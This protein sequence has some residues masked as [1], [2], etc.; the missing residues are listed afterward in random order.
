[1]LS[2][3]V[4]I[5]FIG[6]LYYFLV[7]VLPVSH[8]YNLIQTPEFC[9]SFIEWTTGFTHPANITAVPSAGRREPQGNAPGNNAAGGVF[10][11]GGYNWGSGRVLGTN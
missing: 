3:V 5:P 8:G 2:F 10:P 11:R 1:M 9:I 7:D 6:H 4:I